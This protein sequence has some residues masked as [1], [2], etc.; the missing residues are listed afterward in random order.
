LLSRS[1]TRPWICRSTVLARVGEELDAGRIGADV[2]WVADST[3]GEELKARGLLL[4]DT[5]PEADALP[6]IFDPF[7]TTKAPGEGTGLGLAQVHGIVGSH[8]GAINAKSR[9]GEG[10]AF[11]IYLPA[12]PVHPLDPTVSALEETQTLRKG[13]GE[14]ILIVEDNAFVRG[15]LAE[16]LKLL[17]Y[18]V[19]E[20][21]DGDEAL[22]VLD[23]R[24]EEIALMLS[25]VVMPSMG[26]KALL[27]ALRERGLTIPVVMLTSHHMRKEMEELW[28]QGI[29][30]WLPKPPELEQLA[31]VIAR[32][33]SVGVNG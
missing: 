11:T 20:A 8:E 31:E 28:A 25:D 21:E 2:I 22:T 24:G 7:F 5:T 15:A 19:L 4:Q 14:T 1:N 26:G 23:E 33:L 16:S 6:Y 12:L 18:Q 10:M 30:D 27:H 29:T 32:A 3:V 9:V 13:N 17:D